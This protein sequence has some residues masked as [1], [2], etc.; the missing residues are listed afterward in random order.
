[1]AQVRRET[2]DECVFAI[3]SEV[4]TR[5]GVEPTDLPPLARTIDPDA[6]RDVVDSGRGG[7]VSVRFSYEGYD[8]TVDSD[9]DVRVDERMETPDR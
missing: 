4:A 6:L 9:G 2:S 7:S 8:V 1:M 5:E 3:V